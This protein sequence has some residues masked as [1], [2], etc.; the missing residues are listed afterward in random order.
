MSQWTSRSQQTARTHSHP[1]SGR[2]RAPRP[3]ED[4]PRSA[5]LRERGSP[6]THKTA[7]Y[8]LAHAGKQVRFGPVVF[9]IAVGTVVII[10]GV[11]DH[12]GNLPCF[13]R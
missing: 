12:L 2:T 5:E 1:H 13:S 10:G 7:A 4:G 3:I 8:T 11:V 6:P 9:W